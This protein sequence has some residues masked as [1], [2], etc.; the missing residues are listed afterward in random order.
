[1]SLTIGP[2]IAMSRR[3][4]SHANLSLADRARASTVASLRPRIRTVS[5]IPGIESFAPER[6]ETSSGIAESPNFRPPVTSTA[7]RPSSTCFH[8][9]GGKRPVRVYALQ[10]LVVIVK[11]GGTGRPSPPRTRRH[12]SSGRVP[13]VVARSSYNNVRSHVGCKRCVGSECGSETHLVGFDVRPLPLEEPVH[14][15]VLAPAEE[16]EHGLACDRHLERPA[17]QRHRVAPH[18]DLDPGQLLDQPPSLPP[19][20]DEP[21]PDLRDAVLRVCEVL[22]VEDFEVRVLV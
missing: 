3:Y 2:N 5:I 7:E 16:H 8:I 22:D 18:A 14:G 17:D 19:G 15:L 6:T 10:A 1:M 21:R 11:P 13:I 12:A 20:A 4:A 9:P